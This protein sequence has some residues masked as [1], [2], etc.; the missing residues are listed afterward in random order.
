MKKVAEEIGPM[1]IGVLVPP[2]SKDMRELLT[3]DKVWIDLLR[4]L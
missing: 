3:S 1:A 4:A 2:F